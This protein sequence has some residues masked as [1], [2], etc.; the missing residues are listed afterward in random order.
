MEKN[1]NIFES[2]NNKSYPTPYTITQVIKV[3]QYN[4]YIDILGRGCIK[5]THLVK[6]C[7]ATLSKYH[8]KE[9]LKVVQK[10]QSL[11]V[12][13]LQKFNNIEGYSTPLYMVDK[14]NLLKR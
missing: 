2:L 12:L 10:K 13:V 7:D 3:K 11:F 4:F 5:F 6:E 1:I 14:L 8:E 9:L